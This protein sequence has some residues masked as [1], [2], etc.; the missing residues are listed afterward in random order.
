MTLIRRDGQALLRSEDDSAQLAWALA[1]ERARPYTEAEAAAFLALYQVLRQA[2][3][4]DRRELDEIAGLARQLMP[5]WMQPA[6]IERLRTAV[7]PLPL[8]VGRYDRSVSPL[9]RAA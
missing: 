6:R 9:I 2:L 5:I 1:A 4:R 8:P 3:P 7:R